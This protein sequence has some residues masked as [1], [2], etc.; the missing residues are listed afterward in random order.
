MLKE[1]TA[2]EAAGAGDENRSGHCRCSYW[3]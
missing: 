3:A 1:M 2:G